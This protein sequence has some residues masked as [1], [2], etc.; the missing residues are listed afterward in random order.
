[1]S[2]QAVL[3]TLMAAF[4]HKIKNII[5]SM[6]DFTWAISKLFPVTPTV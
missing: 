4:L 1:M 3:V 2:F 6:Y 5:L